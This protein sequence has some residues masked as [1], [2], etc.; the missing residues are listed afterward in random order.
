[1]ES[2]AAT[3]F[4]GSLYLGIEASSSS[5]Y[6]SIVWKIDFNA[7]FA[8]VSA[9]QL[10][11]ITGSGH[12]WADIGISNGT[13]YDFNG[14]ASS[15]D[16]YHMNMLTHEVTQLT[17]ASGLIPRQVGIDWNGQ[18]YNIGQPSSGSTG[19][20]TPYA[21]NGSLNTASQQTITLNGVAVTGSWGDAAEAFVPKLD[22]GDAPATYDPAGSDPAVHERI[23]TLRLGNNIDDEFTT[24]GQTLLA[25]A[26]NFD[27]GLPYVHIFNPLAGSYFTQVNVFNNT[28]ANATACAWLDYN[29]NGV[30]EASEGISVTVP[31]SGSVQSVYLYWPSTPSS[32]ANNSYTYLRIR[33]ARASSNMTTA[34]PIGYFS[35]GEVEDYRV[36]VNSYPLPI[37]LLSFEARKHTEKSA[38]IQWTVAYASAAKSYELQKSSN[39]SSW[40]TIQTGMFAATNSITSYNFTDGLPYTPNTYYRLK[41]INDDGSVTYSTIQKVSFNSNINWTVGPNPAKDVIT[42]S[43]KSV[44]AGAG[45]ITISDITGKVVY[46]K[47]IKIAEG[48]NV[49]KVNDLSSL[50][51][52]QHIIRLENDGQQF[53]EKLLIKK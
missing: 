10:Y 37:H 52:G 46:Q 43:L 11:G 30:F 15:P 38:A 45:T 28:G 53:T 20:I 47:E 32:L 7:S 22:F 9:S 3:F 18:V 16:F 40:K 12:D 21:Y 44:R 8:P 25:N 19:V 34:N 24:R 17:P 31:S 36:F 48:E 26:D 39:A 41:I 35:D 23:N 49:I 33:I 5:V 13:F 50:G 51:N 1:V 14:S 27:D 4:D 6:E 29:G 2:G 42:I